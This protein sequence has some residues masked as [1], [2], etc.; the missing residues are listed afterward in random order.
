VENVT[1]RAA[2][3]ASLGYSV[4]D[5]LI[6][7]LVILVEGPSDKAI[8]DEFFRMLG[9][10]SAYVIRIWPLG[11]DIMGQLDLAVF[12]DAYRLIA[13][14]DTDP[15]SG[16]V[17]ETFKE[18]CVA[19]GIPVH[20]LN[21]YAIENYLSLPAIERVMHQKAPEGLTKLDPKKKVSDQL[22]FDVKR[23]AASIAREMTLEDLNGTDLFEFLKKAEQMLTGK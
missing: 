16:K 21:R 7:D 19:K 12:S 14:I 2:L 20:Q 8:L 3:L 5:N 11:G 18:K 17:R 10:S 15:K 6:S 13:L 1:S 23:N 4:A 22:G 9:L